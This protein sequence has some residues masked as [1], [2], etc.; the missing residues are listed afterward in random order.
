MYGHLVSARAPIRFG[1]KRAVFSV[2]GA[3]PTGKPRV[4]ECRCTPTS[5]YAR[6]SPQNKD[7]N[8]IKPLKKNLNFVT[9]IRRLNMTP[10][11][12]QPKEKNRKTGFHQNF[13]A[14]QDIKEKSE[15][16]KTAS[17]KGKKYL[18]ITYL[19]RPEPR[20]PD[21]AVPVPPTATARASRRGGPWASCCGARRARP[22]SPLTVSGRDTAG[23]RTRLRRG[24]AGRAREEVLG[25]TRRHHS[26]KGNHVKNRFAPPG[27]R[28]HTE[29]R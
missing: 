3:G 18:Q 14:S 15:S 25:I 6:K 29:G 22:R 21:A 23:V 28:P 12:M 27:P 10:K 1:G 4:K 2:S 8:V 9:W 16:K 26:A 13:C 5:Q 24:R 17:C 7:L 19:M 20:T 11:H